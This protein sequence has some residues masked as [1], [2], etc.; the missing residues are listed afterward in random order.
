MVALVL[1]VVGISVLV[2]PVAGSAPAVI[3]T[4]PRRV[5]VV[6]MPRVTWSVLR[7]HRP[8][9]LMRFL[10]GAAVASMSTR[11]I[12]PRTATGDAYLT[13][14]AGNR[15]GS[16]TAAMPGD[17]A[18]V[19]EQTPNGLAADVYHRRTGIRP[20]GEIVVMSIAQQIAR[21]ADLLYGADPG[22]L[23]S[24]LAAARRDVGVV[25]NA[26]AGF[27]PPVPQREVALSAMRRNGQVAVGNVSDSLLVAD[28]NA[29]FGV[30]MD[31][32]ALVSSVQRG[33]DHAALQI[34]EMS[35]L[36]RAEQARAESTASEGNRQFAEAVRRSDVEL[37]RVLRTVDLTRDL[38]MV[39]SPTSPIDGEQ[40]TVFAM[41]GRGV[42][43]GWARSPTTR[44]AGFVTL[45][46]IAPTI[47][48]AWGIAPPESMNDTP[49]VS[50]PDDLSVSSRIA[51]MIRANER[52][53]FRDGA[54]GPVTVEFIVVLVALLAC[55]MWAVGRGDG[56]L[57]KPLQLWALAVMAGP[58]V[59]YLSGLLP[60]SP[61]TLIS[62]SL[63]LG[64][65]S[66]VVAGA[67]W[68]TR[69]WDP[70]AAPVL[71]ALLGVAVLGV[72]VVTGGNLQLNTPFGYSPI[73][74]GRFAGY[75]NQAFSILT[76]CA[77]IVVTGGW[78]I[79][80]RR[81]PGSG[82]LGRSLV[83]IAV[84]AVVIV[85]DGAPA[86]G[87]DVGGVIST[88]PAF[89]VC[90]LLLLGRRV[91]WR[92]AAVIGACTAGALVVF[93]AI[94]LARPVES[95]THLGRFAQ[96]LIDG[97]GGIILQRKIEANLS[98]LTSTI[99]T[100]V[101]P[102]ALLFIGYLTWRPNRMLRRLH[103]EHFGFKAFGVSG[104]TLGI[105]AWIAND[106]G[107]SIPALMLTVALPYT[108]YLAL[109]LRPRGEDA[110]A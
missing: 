41:G 88:I 108:A 52:A 2:G 86:W 19:A 59:M 75:G 11:T 70:V 84:F 34:V 51:T 12:G 109:G 100:L 44:R 9:N 62:Y 69:G 91:R 6:S 35:D 40:L 102:V 28:P 20:T 38:V 16:L 90:M 13:I 93:A 101:I 94:D 4:S 54:T 37:G 17:A 18:D 23:A 58:T 7:Q 25:G 48:D 27:D 50:V 1:L 64:A 83:A 39:L 77:L 80:R 71:V 106:S 87:S 42:E 92:V 33:W 78:E 107:V 31:A 15:A 103:E 36:E 60:Y 63:A 85:L 30:R 67:S 89:S 105:V 21:S 68:P 74:A 10:R 79:W 65:A 26:D 66:L 53:L 96:K 104:M 45:T 72:D 3:D 61:F 46:D 14:G 81:R 76:I 43:P 73:V 55:V 47:L 57:S 82:D 56:R 22:A 98:I 95:R 29:P 99:W 97:G 5:L 32:D 110:D 24:A 8:Q 49:I